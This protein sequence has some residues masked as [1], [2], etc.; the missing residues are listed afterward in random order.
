MKS[1]LVLAL[2]IF[3]A[4]PSIAKNKDTIRVEPNTLDLKHLQTGDFSYLQYVKKAKYGPASWITLIKFNVEAK[5]YNKRPA[6]VVNQQW[7]NDTVVHKCLT[8][9]D[10]KNFSTILHDTYWKRLGYSI[11]FNFETRVVELTNV[12]LK[13]GIPDSIKSVAVNDFNE[14]FN[15]YNLN[16]HA[17]M[18]IY[19]LLPYKENRTFIINY[20]DPGFGK[21]E[22]VMY[23]VTGSD[24]LT[25]GNGEKI[26]C[27]VL[28]NY[29]DN[30]APEKGYERF[31]IAKKTHEVLKLENDFGN[32]RGYRYKLKLGI[33]GDK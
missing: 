9:F 2:S 5:Q 29:N 18:I 30:K 31:W 20:Y 11:K 1:F 26:D 24:F 17:D 27:W 10:A 4:I 6:Y 33:S 7:E 3:F 23:T 32:G 16:W 22:E 15:K 28:N 21:A 19:S 12:N 25:G 8:V 14:S 13:E